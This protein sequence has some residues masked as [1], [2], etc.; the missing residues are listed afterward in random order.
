M[1]TDD[2]GVAVGDAVALALPGPGRG[3]GVEAVQ[4]VQLS[5]QLWSRS[6]SGVIEPELNTTHN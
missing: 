4:V 6:G 5:K 3:P 1:S 2:D